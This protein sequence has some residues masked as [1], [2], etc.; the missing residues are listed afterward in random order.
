M[1]DAIKAMATAQSQIANLDDKQLCA[2]AFGISKTLRNIEN[3]ATVKRKKVGS[4]T[5]TEQIAEM[6]QIS[7]ERKLQ[8]QKVRGELSFVYFEL[9]ERLGAAKISIPEMPFGAQPILMSEMLAGASPLEDSA[10][11]I[12]LLAKKLCH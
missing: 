4:I 1:A 2:R 7:E 8:F 3:D 11:Y 10:E 12:E 5:R 9:V 6:D